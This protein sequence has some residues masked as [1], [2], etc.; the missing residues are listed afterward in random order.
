MKRLK[1][2]VGILIVMSCCYLICGCAIAPIIGAM[3]V[4]GVEVYSVK[5]SLEAMDVKG[6]IKGDISLMKTVSVQVFEEMGIAIVPKQNENGENYLKGKTDKHETIE[7]A[8]EAV[9]SKMFSVGIKARYPG[10]GFFETNKDIN[11]STEIIYAIDEKYKTGVIASKS[12]SGTKMLE[13]VKSGLVRQGPGP[14]Y[15][16]VA[17][18]KPGNILFNLGKQKS[19]Y[20]IQTEKG[21]VGFV[22][23]TIVKPTQGI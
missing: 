4:T 10:I 9:T 6:K 11:L 17:I 20:K 8:W 16:V 23:Y 13:A 1:S 14:K 19:W 15:K 18:V 5:H 22:Y 7:I 2:I 12:P 3:G 21:K